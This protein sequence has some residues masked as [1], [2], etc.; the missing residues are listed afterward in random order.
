MVV[1]GIDAGQYP[2]DFFL[3]EDGRQPVL[4]LGAEDIEDVPVMP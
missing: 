2:A 3:A 1:G 4:R